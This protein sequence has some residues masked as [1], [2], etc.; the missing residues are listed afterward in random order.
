MSESKEMDPE[1]GR[2]VGIGVIDGELKKLWDEDEA[3]TNAS[4]VNVAIYSEELGSL[5]RN[6]KIIGKITR[7]HACRALLI[8]IDRQAAE[9]SIRSWI[10]AHCHLSGGQKAVCCEQIAFELKGRSRGRL[11]NTVFAHL[12]SDLPLI[13]WWQGELSNLFEGS[14]Y[15]LIDRFIFDSSDWLADPLASFERIELA[16]TDSSR[17]LVVQDLAWTRT[18]HYRLAVA[19]LFDSAQAQAALTEIAAVELIAHPQHRMSALQLVAW[20]STQAQWALVGAERAELGETLRF[21]KK[22]AGEVRVAIQYSESSAP[23]GSLAM[24]A[25]SLQLRVRRDPGKSHLFHQL[26]AGDLH[27]EG[28]T[29]ADSDEDADLIG[30]QLARG[31]KNSLYRRMLPRFLELLRF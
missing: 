23:L 2:E 30:D 28:L 10:T 19:G 4:L 22:S 13:F 6:S 16:V 26:V 29:P 9:P 21:S 8:E 31:G 14:L 24:T 20:L 18:Y 15:S 7:D 5:R 17:Q 11:R 27:L 12:A 1:L 3:R 25:R